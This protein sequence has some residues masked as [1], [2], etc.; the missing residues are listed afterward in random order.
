MM[1]TM[2]LHQQMKGEIFFLI[3]TSHKTLTFGPYFLFCFSSSKGNSEEE[4]GSDQFVDCTISPPPYAKNDE[5]KNV[6]NGIDADS[7]AS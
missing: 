5:Q 6:L 7:D 1:K 2:T 3:K 4:A